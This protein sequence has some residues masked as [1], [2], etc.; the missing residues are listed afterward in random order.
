MRSGHIRVLSVPLEADEDAFLSEADSAER[1]D[2]QGM[3]TVSGRK[4]K[5][6]TRTADAQEFGALV[7]RTD[8][9]EESETGC[10]PPLPASITS[11]DTTLVTVTGKPVVKRKTL[12]LFGRRRNT[13]PISTVSARLFAISVFH[14]ALSLARILFHTYFYPHTQSANDVAD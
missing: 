9:E 7:Q 13:D 14:R 2:D 12:N 5:D 3:N 1:H 6:R 4:D 10:L 11:R 8:G